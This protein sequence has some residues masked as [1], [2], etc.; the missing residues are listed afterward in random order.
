MRE[1]EE[2]S[3]G[4]ERLWEAYRQATPEPETVSPH[5]MPQLWARIEAGRPFGWTVPLQWLAARMLPAAAALIVAL[6]V[7]TWLPAW[8][9]ARGTALQSG[10]VDELVTDL[11]EEER[12]DLYLG[13][14]EEI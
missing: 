9:A 11:W 13:N 1:R 8:N 4:L 7:Y 5:F 2:E 12:P 14:G 10:Y 6:G 3:A